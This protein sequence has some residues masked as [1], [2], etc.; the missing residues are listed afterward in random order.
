MKKAFTIAI[1]FMHDFAAGCWL[2]TVLA[3][4]R[5]EQ[6]S[7]GPGP[8]AAIMALQ[9]EFFYI[10]IAC[11]VVVLGAGTGRT[12][13]YVNNVYG[14]DVETSRRRMLIIKHAVLMTAFGLGTFW[15]YTM[16]YH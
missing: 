7:L 16:I 9:K 12:F 13:T 2:A 6:V 4:Y 15:Q 5:L 3:V 1:G 11:I 14:E 10:G 8:Q